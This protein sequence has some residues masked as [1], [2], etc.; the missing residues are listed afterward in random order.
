MQIGLDTWLSIASSLVGEGV[1]VFTGSV[2]VAVADGAGVAVKSD[3]GMNF[4]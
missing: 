4:S 2:R 3:A 1:F